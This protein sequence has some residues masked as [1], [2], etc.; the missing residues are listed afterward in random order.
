MKRRNFIQSILGVSVF[1]KSHNK[2]IPAHQ[3]DGTKLRLQNPDGTWGLWIDLIG[4]KGN[5]GPVG[6]PGAPGRDA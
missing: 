4:P 5:M 1:G 3:W 2:H 6:Q